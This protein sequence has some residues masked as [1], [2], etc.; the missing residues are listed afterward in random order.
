MADLL[1][2][3]FYEL[4]AKATLCNGWNYMII[5]WQGVFTQEHEENSQNYPI[6]YEKIYI[7]SFTYDVHEKMEFLDPLPLF[8][9]QN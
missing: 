1:H 3:I 2:F 8:L 9:S 4:F 7:G 6:S 5:F